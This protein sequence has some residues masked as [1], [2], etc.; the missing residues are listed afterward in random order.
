MTGTGK[1][2]LARA[3]ERRVFDLSRSVV[4]LDGEDLRTGMSRDL[5]FDAAERS[6]HLR[7]AAEVAR[8]LN[9]HGHLVILAVQ[10]PAASVRARIRD[11]LGD[12]RYVEIH[13]DAPEAVR[14]ERDPSGLYAAAERGEIGELP[15]VTVA[16]EPPE[17]P[18]LVFDTS[19]T[20]L[21]ASVG[22]II[23]LLMARGLL[24]GTNG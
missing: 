19:L 2:T 10:A 8:I 12:E 18:D 21:D 3:L 23:E 24:R 17:T 6:E 7:R 13:L 22:T 1:S 4:R 15:G 16:Y 14:R 5:G 20:D 11:L 9:D